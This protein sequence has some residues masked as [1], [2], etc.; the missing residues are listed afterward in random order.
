MASDEPN[1]FLLYNEREK[2][3]DTIVAELRNRG[4]SL[5][6]YRS[7]LRYG[8]NIKEREA[9]KMRHARAAVILL[10]DAGW[11]ISQAELAQEAVSLGKPILPVLIGS[12]P[13]E[14]MDQVGS[15]FRLR[16]RLDLRDPS[17]T[18]F[19][20]LARA[21]EMLVLETGTAA[22]GSPTP[23]AP[24]F[25]EV[26]NI[27][28][29]GNDLDRSQVLQ[30]LIRHPV[31]NSGA[32]ALRLRDAITSDFSSSQE[33]QFAT[34]VRAPKSLAST[35][36]W[37]LSVL[38]WVEP[39]NAQSKAII[40]E[41]LQ[42][43]SEP[44][45]EVRFWV[46]AGIVQ[47]GLTYLEEALDVARDDP[48]PEIA[49]LAA[50]VTN[51]G[52]EAVLLT[53]RTALK[54]EDFETVWYVLRILRIIAIPALA[55]EVLEQ[56]HRSADG[57]SLTYDALFALASPE[58]ANAV[59]PLIPTNMGLDKFVGLLLREARTATPVARNAFA[60]ILTVFDDGDVRQ[61]LENMASGGRDQQLVRQILYDI[62][63]I[64]KVDIPGAPSIAGFSSDVINI[65]QDDIGIANDVDT[66]ASVML[67]RDVTPPLAIGLFGEWGSGKSFFMRSI[68]AAASRIAD[69][70]KSR[71]NAQFCAE[72]VQIN[73]NAWHYADSNLWASLVS[74]ILDGLSRHIAPPQSKDDQHATLSG[75]LASAKAEMASAQAEQERASS[76][77][78]E[79]AK[80][81][82]GTIFERQRREVRLRD[83]RAG[84]LITLLD[85]SKNGLDVTIKSALK[86]VGAPAALE[87]ID[88][89][90][91]VV[92]DSY[93]TAGRAAAFMVSLLTGRNAFIVTMGIV[94]FFV[95]P[96]LI[97]WGIGHVLNGY[98]AQITAM[99]TKTVVVA[100]SITL[101]LK[102]A[103]A[104]AKTGLD[105]LSKAKRRVDQEL[106]KKRETPS[107][108]ERRLE[109]EVLE[110][111]VSEK[112]ASERLSVATVRARD[113]EDRVARLKET[114][115][116]GYFI[117]E[118]SQ[119][120][121]YHRHLGL[122]SMIRKDF[123]GLVAHLKSAET[124][125][126]KQ[127]DRIILYVDDVDRCPP[128]MVV[129]ILQAVHL[130]LAYELFVVVVSVDPRWLLRSLESRFTTLQ[131][132]AGAETWGATPQD[133]LEKI[134]QIP[135]S[136]RPMGE[137]G[138][139][140]LMDRL[141]VPPTEPVPSRAVAEETQVSLYTGTG[142][143]E[144]LDLP[145]KG[146]REGGGSGSEAQSNAPPAPSSLPV[147][148]D[149]LA[150]ALQIS[151]PELEF[152][153]A[154]SKLLR[155]PRTAKRFTNI[156][157]LLKASLPRQQLG[158]F[159]GS[160]GVPGEFQLPML[161]LAFLVGQAATA[162]LVFPNFL[163]NARDGKLTWW[164]DA[165]SGSD[166]FN[167]HHRLLAHFGEIASGVLFPGSPE[168][169]VHWLPRVAR[170]SFSTA[171]LYLREC[172]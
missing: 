153:R 21:I 131:T 83:L 68:E 81:L 39:N 76:H 22:S 128:E 80:T 93:S 45:R 139:T 37:M 170:Y 92:A 65:G 36:S 90:N 72:I 158:R 30:R 89:L 111:K 88:D 137:R 1:I 51:P 84:D 5:Y 41:H 120:G 140:R 129:D 136:V 23:D 86:T 34:A 50:I 63:T 85:D 7:D 44:D 47:R 138:F 171:G 13:E 98:A 29:D 127:I 115:S 112:A 95:V 54:A 62:A 108:D 79:S 117:A 10:G 125:R 159:E 71:D 55:I 165:L 15:L 74:H 154:L 19:D 16:R 38:I 48:A 27:L 53:F 6:F 162:K 114:Q 99:M 60:H 96:P 161:L 18:G 102:T 87:S 113:L 28:V 155:T 43:S 103:V 106:A 104:K 132:A 143:P 59:A 25:D 101:V 67:A 97:E 94:I 134:F 149:A 142:K 116:L 82:Q 33:D 167:D 166:T 91:K 70:A 100:S 73:F 14:A 150:D 169:A 126:G 109:A 40:L 144:N 164:S 64:R 152:A 141:L 77:L 2:L 9:S 69:E 107:E 148:I 121:D 17:E 105:A 20:E 147:E 156:Y 8:E 130:L 4:T 157:R 56:L 11:G 160:E 110:A 35:R 52:S 123:D 163:A 124:E 46:L 146:H 133:Y 57:K 61:S 3:P 135:F 75:E 12:P 58:M 42:F 145:V 168:L 66:L 151:V 172:E 24:R 122:I 26:I 118:R 78:E 49:G 31:A 119:S 32:L